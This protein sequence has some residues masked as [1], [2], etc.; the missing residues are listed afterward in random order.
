MAGSG[1]TIH[2]TPTNEDK[3][4]SSPLLKLSPELRNRIYEFA[5]QEEDYIEI[6]SRLKP[7]SLL[8]TCTRIH[9]E[10][11]ALWF[12]LNNFA[13]DIVD[14]NA[15]VFFAFQEIVARNYPTSTEIY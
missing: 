9:D 14:C 8:S 13:A 5:L 1:A 15:H 7:P 12:E 6:I 3:K 10:A 11:T 4:V 2:P